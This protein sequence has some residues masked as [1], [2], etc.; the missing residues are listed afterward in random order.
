M[1]N[2]NPLKVFIETYGCTFNQADSQIIAG[3]LTENN[4]EI[5]DNIQDSQIA[6]INTCYVKNPTENKV[7][8][9]IKKLQ[10]THPDKKIV[11]S[12]CMVEIDPKKLDKIAPNSSWIG[13][14]KLNKSSDIV[15]RTFN[16]EIVR[17]TGF[18]KNS[19]VGVS[20][21]RFDPL[22]HII[23]ICE[24]CLGICTYCCTRFARG[25]L[26][27]YS[28]NEIVKEADNAIK[29]DCIEVQLTAQDTA[30]FGR[31]SHEKLSTLI[32]EISSLDGDFKARI[33]MMHPKNVLYDLN[34]LIK[35]FQSKKVYKFLHL[36]VQ[37]GSN[38][39]L[40]QMK[41]GHSV[42]EFK[43]I[44]KRFKEKI[45]N[46]TIATD[47]I[48]GYPTE[49]DEDFQETVDLLNDLKPNLIHISKYKH[50]KG[51][52]SSDLNEIPSTIMKKRSKYLTAIKTQITEEENNHL[53]NTIQKVLIVGNGKK[54]GF[55]GK[56]DS[57]IP[58]IVN[59]ANLGDFIEVKITETTS[60]YLKGEKIE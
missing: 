47:I 53:L 16:N 1:E 27:S 34:D 59:N 51:A 20:K 46:I 36:P 39:V 13:P 48:V 29:E 45:P 7:S 28:I 52:T 3:L 11:V 6:I 9:K 40:E 33:G 35:S 60:T 10:E 57:Y 38:N 23:Q 54:S 21:F 24:G 15:N 43:K 58:V 55:I 12:G 50:R 19:K 31:D 41:R 18:S 14:H 30:A 42:E 32:N 2:E 56:T 26:H 44:V 8:N 22:I 4:V 17:E 25:S 5:V 49:S 37:S